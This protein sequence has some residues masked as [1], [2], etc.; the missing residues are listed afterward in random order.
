MRAVRKRLAVGALMLSAAGGAVALAPPRDDGPAVCPAACVAPA[1]HTL[2]APARPESAVSLDWAGPPA[3]TLGKPAEYTLSVRNLS[4]QPAQKTVVQVRPPRDASVQH[5]AP[6]AKVVDGVYVWDLGTLDPRSATHLKLTMTPT[7]RGEMG[8]QAWVTFTGTAGMTV[9]VREPKVVVK[10]SAP[11]A[12]TVGDTFKVT[13]TV[14]NVGDA[15]AENVRHALGR[16]A[17]DPLDINVDCKKLA[18]LQ[19]GEEW[20]E[21]ADVKA[22]HGGRLRVAASARGWGAADAATADATVVVQVPKLTTTVTG[23]AAVLVGREARYLVCIKNTGDVPVRMTQIQT[24][25]PTGW[26]TLYPTR[27]ADPNEPGEMSPGGSMEWTQI[28][29][30]TT[31][32]AGTVAVEATGTRGVKSIGSCQTAVHGIAALRMELVDSVDPVEKGDQTTYEIRV[33][34][35][36][37]MADENVVVSCPL[38]EQFKLVSAHGPVGYAVQDLGTCT[39]VRFDPVRELAPKTDAAFKVTVKAVAAGDVRF[40]AQLTSRH[41]TTSVAKEESTRVYG[42]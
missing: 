7:A 10:V 28:V 30:P 26:R 15:P 8:S 5:T 36:G 22:D 35:T 33:T 9:A 4:A 40:K 14:K 18:V 1:A 11:E 2:D 34:N 6:A 29:V 24:H 41:L 23:P 13:Y 21:T 37:T 3:A 20:T 16:Y 17:T 38:P 25:L 39:V 27:T 31:V 32:G 42:D 19:P 12:V